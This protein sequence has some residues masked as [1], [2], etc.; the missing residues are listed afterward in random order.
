MGGQKDDRNQVNSRI[1]RDSR[2]T[3]FP[4]SRATP[5]AE[6]MKIFQAHGWP[7]QPWEGYD[8]FA[9]QAQMTDGPRSHK[10]VFNLTVSA[11]G[12]ILTFETILTPLPKPPWL[13][14]REI[15]NELNL[16]SSGS[17][18]LL[19]ECGIVLRYKLVLRRS[20]NHI[21]EDRLMQVMS[22]LNHD[23][24]L[25]LPVIEEV[26]RTGLANLP[27]VRRMFTLNAA[28]RTS[29]ISLSDLQMF[30]NYAGFFSLREGQI[31]LVS[32]DPRPGERCPVRMTISHGVIRAWTYPGKD[33][34]NKRWGTVRGLL[35]FLGNNNTGQKFR[36]QQYG[37]VLKVLGEINE[38]ASLLRFVWK[39]GRVL[40]LVTCAPFETQLNNEEFNSYLE[41]LFRCSREGTSQ[42]SIFRR[43]V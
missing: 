28:Q 42:T 34:P 6:A 25:A 37:R 17:L 33:M 11:N 3:P 7:C 29:T 35:K 26:S 38:N 31:V 20:E 30:A 39:D 24:V 8:A 1:H 40:A 32:R 12:P 13:A 36:W 41:A 16:R 2:A 43:A 15:L 5:A 10:N 21:P 14:I 27:R 9:L 4:V 18:F 19:R 22:R 23:R